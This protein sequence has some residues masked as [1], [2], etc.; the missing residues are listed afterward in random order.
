MLTPAVLL[1]RVL[2]G[3]D[4]E[5]ERIVGKNKGVSNKPIS[6]KIFSPHVSADKHR[7]CLTSL[8]SLVLCARAG[9]AP[10]ARRPAGY[11]QGER[12]S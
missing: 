6:L 5:T 7:R 11:H 8:S 1:A 2:A 3:F 4:S 9:L 10:D 12:N